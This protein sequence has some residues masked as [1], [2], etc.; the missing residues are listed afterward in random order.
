V[1][2]RWLL[3]DGGRSRAEYAEALAGVRAARSR[4]ADF[5]RQLTFEVRQR[6]LELDSNRAAVAAAEDGLRSATEARRVVGERFDAGVAISTD[7]LDAELAV[8]Q[9]GLDRTRALA[10]VR[11][12]EARLVRAVGQ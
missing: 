11:L 4:M 2:A 9:A 3:W 7:V 5:D 10:N 12:A 1:S 8:L 6:W